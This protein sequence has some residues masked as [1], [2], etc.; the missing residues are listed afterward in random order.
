M[1]QPHFLRGIVRQHLRN[2]LKRKTTAEVA[3]AQHHGEQRFEPGAARRRAP[4]APGLAREIAVD[5]IG[6]DGVDLTV[7]DASPKG[8]TIGRFAQWRI[9]LAGVA[10]G[11]AD[12]VRQIVRTGFDGDPATAG[13]GAKRRLERVR[14]CGVNDI[15]PTAGRLR[16]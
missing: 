15:E 6:C 2:A 12:V 5:M 7:G 8:F 3:L 4:D 1:P 14:R 10:A 9:D 16:R 11:K 13:A